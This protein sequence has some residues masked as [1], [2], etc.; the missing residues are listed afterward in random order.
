MDTATK[1]YNT[2]IGDLNVIMLSQF[3]AKEKKKEIINWLEAKESSSRHKEFSQKRVSGSGMWFV[4]SNEFKDWVSGSSQ[5]L[6]GSGNGT[7]HLTIPR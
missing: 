4:E 6:I 1:V 2:F 5:I 7:V 3:L